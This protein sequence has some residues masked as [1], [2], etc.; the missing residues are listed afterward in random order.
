MYKRFAGINDFSELMD[1]REEL[2]DR[3]GDLPDQAKSFYETH[4]LRLEM[5]GFGIKKIDATPSAIQIQFIPNPP[6]D[7]L[8][9]IQLIQ[10]AK[11][12]QLNGQDKLKILPIKLNDFAKLE[13]R[14]DHIRQVLRRLNESAVLSSTASIT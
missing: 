6:I 1:L 4:R 2:V 3:Y 7:P 9:I 12:I 8:K 10:S 14:L 5:T 13:Q 11:N